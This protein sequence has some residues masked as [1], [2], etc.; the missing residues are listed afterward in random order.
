MLSSKCENGLLDNRGFTVAEVITAIGVFAIVMSIAV[1][2]YVALQPARRLNGAAR[3]VLVQLMWARLKAVQENNRFVVSL[4]NNHTLQI[5]DDD[6]NNGAADAGETTRTI[7]IQT[8]YPDVT[9]SK[10][11]GDPTFFPR[12]TTG[13]STTFTVTNSSGSKTITVSVTGNVKL[14]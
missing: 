10:S 13:G 7:N 12:G 4:P 2:N 1:P 3:D 8:D 11:G 9:L 6:N 14:N 5:L